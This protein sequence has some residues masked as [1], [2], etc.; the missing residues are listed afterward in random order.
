MAKPLSQKEIVTTQQLA[1]STMLEIE[2]SIELLGEKGIITYFKSYLTRLSKSDGNVLFPDKT[3]PSGG[4]VQPFVNQN[5]LT[6]TSAQSFITREGLPCSIAR[7]SFHPQKFHPLFQP[8]PYLS[9]TSLPIL[10][11]LTRRGTMSILSHI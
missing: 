5:W 4:Y 2:S 8:E 3:K 6:I 1:I 11:I 7:V 9:I 10:L